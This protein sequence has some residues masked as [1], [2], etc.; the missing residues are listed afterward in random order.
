MDLKRKKQIIKYM[1]RAVKQYNL[2]EPNDVIAVGVSG[3]K[4]S[5]VLL[6]CLATI[7]NYKKVPFKLIAITI[8]QGIPD[9]NYKEMENFIKNLNI[10]YYNFKTDIFEIIF[11]VRKEKNPCSLCAKMRR[12]AL[13]E[14]AKELGANK[15]AL[16]HHANDLIETF[17]LSFIYEGRL[18]TFMPKTYMSKTEIT[19]IRPMI[20]VPE[21]EII[22]ISKDFPIVKN[23]CPADKHSN[24]EYV[25]DIVKSIEQKVKISETNMLNAITH[26]ERYNLFDK[27]NTF[28][29]NSEE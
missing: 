8:N 14:K 17:L 9:E 1:I 21:K 27:L 24:R 5:L 7:K 12:G 23:P 18:S 19:C 25:K 15:I 6:D 28:N 4:D 29:D 16:G 2:I 26:P 22:S 3:G 13:C 20:Y 10:P 11:D